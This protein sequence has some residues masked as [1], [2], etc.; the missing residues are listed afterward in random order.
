MTCSEGLHFYCTLQRPLIFSA[1]PQTKN[2]NNNEI[3]KL[4][5]SLLSNVLHT[6]LRQQKKWLKCKSCFPATIVFK[7][8]FS[9]KVYINW[10]KLLSN[11]Q[12]HKLLFV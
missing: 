6:I 1:V 7:R 8:D 3:V 9:H 5:A 10:L 4:K 11:L 12:S 2:N